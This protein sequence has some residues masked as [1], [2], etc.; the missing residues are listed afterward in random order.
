[1]DVTQT[2]AAPLRTAAADKAPTSLI[3]ADFEMFLRMMTTQLQNQDPQNPIDSADYAVQLATFSGVEQ[4]AR[5]NSL[6]ESM[7]SQFGLM[8]MAQ[9]AG[10]VG[11][12]ARTAAPVW[13]SGQPVT[14]SPEPAAGATRTV[15]AVYD[16]QGQLVSREDIPVSREAVEWAPTDAEGNPL[17]EGSY[18][19]KLESYAGEEKIAGTPV[20]AYARVTE[21]RSGPQGTVVVLE[22]GAEVP[23]SA[24]TALRA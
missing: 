23:A 14:L 11:R 13:V 17:P 20:E 1:M 6:L 16:A 21:I 3:N 4:Q 10:W 7:Q 8:G 5:T 24:V 18:T 12:E 9:M 22:G 15:L 2:A 19:F